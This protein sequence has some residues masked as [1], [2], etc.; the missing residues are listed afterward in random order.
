VRDDFARFARSGLPR[1]VEG[2]LRAAYGLDVTGS[3]AGVPLKNPWGK[4]S[5]QLSMRRSQ[6]EE[7]CEAGLGFVVLKTVIAQDAEGGRAMAAWAIKE[8]RMVAGRIVGRDSGAEGWT[9]SW[10]GRGWWQTFDEYLDLVRAASTLGRDRGMLV[11]PSV[12]YHLPTPDE[13]AWRVE[14]YTTTTRA[15][16]DAYA[17]PAGV[18]FLPLEKDFSPTLAGSDRARQRLKTLEWL[19]E[20]PPLIRGAAPAG[21]VKVGLKLFNSLDDD[22]FQLE[23][24]AAVHDPGPSHPDFLVYANRLFDPDRVF[25]G[26]RGI[27]Y[28]GPDLSDRNLR[29]LSALRAGQAAGTI[30]RAG[31]EISATGDIGSGRMA[32]EYA[33][34]GAA[35]FQLHTFFQLP[36]DAYAMTTG[37]KLQRALHMLYFHPDEGLVTWMLHAARR[38]GLGDRDPI[39]LLDLAARGAA[40]GLAVG[41]LDPQLP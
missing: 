28:G 34:R 8:A 29:L 21:A 13:D 5:G 30:R 39:R 11:V 26:H 22:A 16:L 36:P 1:D 9:V 35:S 20:T 6:V 38:L 41:D 32:V 18:S 37:T 2:Y 17:R 10:K 31:P 15:L 4:A 14:E 19:R 23:L 3:Y 12:K 24:L 33:L 27:A 7:A 25:E 40:S